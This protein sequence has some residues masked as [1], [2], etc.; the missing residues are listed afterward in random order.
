MEVASFSQ[1]SILNF[2]EFE[3]NRSANITNKSLRG[4]RAFGKDYPQA[5]LHIV[6]LGK[7]KQYHENIDVIPFEDILKKLPELLG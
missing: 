7:Q 3:I 1:G 5:K 4:L 2:S 6:Y